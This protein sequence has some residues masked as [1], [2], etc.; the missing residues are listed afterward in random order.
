MSRKLFK[1]TLVISSMTLISRLLGFARDVVLAI[2]FGAGPAFDAFV[3]AFKI[4]NFMRR[5]FGEG[6]FAQAFVPVLSDY[7]ANRKP[8]E[9]REFINH[10]AGTLGAALLIVV[11]LAEILAPV[12]I[13]V[14]APGFVCDPVRLAYTTHMLRITSPYLFLIALTAFAGATLNTFNRFGIPAFTPVLLNVAMIAVAGLWAPHALTQIYILAWGVLLGGILQLLIQIPFLYHLNLFPVP[15][16]QWRHPGVMR[17]L[18]L[19]VPALFG[20][21]VAQI[22]LLMD[23]F[24]ASFLAAGNISWLYYSDRLTYLPLGVIGVALATVVLPNLARQH[25][26]K[27]AQAYSATLD[28][29]LRMAMLIG[30]PAAVALFILAAP[31]LATLIYHGAFTAHDVLM[32]RRSLWAFSVGLPGFMLIK[33]LA[34]AFYSRQNVKTPVKIAA[35]A[36]V[37]N[38]TLNAVLIH[39]LAHAGLA[40]ATSLASS[41]NA[42]LLL[43]FLLRDKIYQPLP[44]WI[45]LILRLLFA[46]GI[47]GLTISAFAGRVDHWLMW[48]VMERVWHLVV[49][50]LLG[51]LSYVAALW[52]SR[53]RLR[54]LRPPVNID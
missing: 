27:S 40:L 39:P 8:E 32:T 54:D 25:S 26:Q 17:V 49:L 16:W 41:F 34:S 52:I 24:F 46:N 22:S 19:M 23:N 43:Y 9:V 1:S 10:I 45:K 42:M 21:S 29:A 31:L 12:I 44:N 2:I 14:F 38:L 11:A 28:W 37:V 48:S 47:M 36:V 6:A 50:I 51:L 7:R 30:V 15:K 53:L 35:A 13:M 5:L 18:K 20:V 3:V 4:P 33:I